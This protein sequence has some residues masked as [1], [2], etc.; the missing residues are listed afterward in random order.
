MTS[1]R[2]ILKGAT[3]TGT[4]S[5]LHSQLSPS[6][7]TQVGFHVAPG[8]S[9]RGRP[10][11]LSANEPTTIK[12]S[13][14]DTGGQLVVFES[15]TSVGNGPELHKHHEQDEWWHVLEGEFIFQVGEEKFRAKP[16]MTVFGPRGVPHSFLSVGSSPGRTIISFQPAGRMEEFFAELAKLST[17]GPDAPLDNTRY[18]MESVGP[19][20]TPDGAK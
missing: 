3:L 13:A 19:R 10:I 2:T 1:R 12:I 16:G 14:S 20:V 5:L 8:E 18:G 7:R 6:S 17:L 11:M 9:R 4:T 15:T